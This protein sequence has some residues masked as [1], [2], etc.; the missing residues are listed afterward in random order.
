MSSIK[1]DRELIRDFTANAEKALKELAESYGVAITYKGGTFARDGGDATIKYELTAPNPVTGAYET[2]AAK[3]F[4][5]LAHAFGLKPTD[6]GTVFTVR[7]TEYRITGLK[8]TR[9][10]FPICAERVKDGKAFKFPAGVVN[11]YVVKDTE[12]RAKGQAG[13]EGPT[14]EPMV[15]EGLS[16]AVQSAFVILAGRLSPENLTCDG[17][18][19]GG[20]VRRRRIGIMNEWRALENRAGRKV[21]ELEAWDFA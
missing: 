7:G 14:E 6:L 16:E 21:S 5:K 12:S 4:A 11:G 9:P 17:E 8:A 2:A 3:D 20:E 10:K 18:C 15:P 1:I 19:S 13:A